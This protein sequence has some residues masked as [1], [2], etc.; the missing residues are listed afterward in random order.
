MRGVIDVTGNTEQR[1]TTGLGYYR[2]RSNI[3]ASNGFDRALTRRRGL[4]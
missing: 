2:A 3:P 1:T 4:T